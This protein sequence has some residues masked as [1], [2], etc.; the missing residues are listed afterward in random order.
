MYSLGII[1]LEMWA[2]FGS[3]MERDLILNE[4]KHKRKLNTQLIEEKKI[5]ERAVKIIEWLVQEQ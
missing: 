5:P 2:E 4:L 1:F 3:S